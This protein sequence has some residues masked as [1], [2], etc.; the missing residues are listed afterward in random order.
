MLFP[1]FELPGPP[2]STSM[3]FTP[4][5]ILPSPRPPTP[6]STLLKPIRAPRSSPLHHGSGNCVPLPKGV[7]P[8]ARTVSFTDTLVFP[9]LTQCVLENS[10]CF[11]SSA[12][13]P[14]LAR[15]QSIPG[16]RPSVGRNPRE[17]CVHSPVNKANCRA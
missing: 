14:N 15:T 7:V 2:P 11:L 6:L 16:Q 17:G 10:K 8:W 9:P 4:Q 13:K 1:P 3:G 5:G 12:E